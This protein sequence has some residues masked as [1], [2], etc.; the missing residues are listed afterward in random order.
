MTTH[1]GIREDLE[2]AFHTL[3]HHPKKAEKRDSEEHERPRKHFHAHE[4]HDK[5]YHIEK[6]HGEGEMET[7]SAGDLDEVHDA[8]EEHFGGPNEGEQEGE[9][10]EEHK[11]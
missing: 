5:T 1:K 8:L 6:D 3:T 2:S 9:E 10:H 7:A 11:R 4:L